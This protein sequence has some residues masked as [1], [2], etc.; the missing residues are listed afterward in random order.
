MTRAPLLRLRWSWRDLRARWLQ[1][2]AI[3]LVIGIGSGLYSGLSSVSEWRR[4][5]YPASYD[6]L[7]MFDVRVDFADGVRLDADRLEAAA[8]AGELER[9]VAAAEARLLVDVQVDASTSTE[10][11]L[12]PGRI[13]GVDTRDG[14]PSVNQVAAYEGR[15]LAGRDMRRPTAVIEATF[16]DE[17]GIT[18]GDTVTVSGDRE[19]EIVGTGSSPEQFFV[20]SDRGGFFAEFAYLYTSLGTAQRI[21]GEPGAADDLV[22]R[23]ADGVDVD[24]A[25]ALLADALQHAFPEAGFDLIPREEDPVLRILFDDIEGDQRL[26]DVFAVVILAGAAFAAF[27][28]V[29]RVVESQRREIG[30]AMALGVEPLHIS[31][32][33]LLFGAQVALLG[34]LFGVGVGALVGAGMS[35]V[36]ES[37][38][39]LPV[40]RTGFQPEVF[41]R[42]AVIGLLLPFAAAVLPV[43]R[44]VRVDPVDALRTN[45]TAGSGMV[46]LLR[47]V[48]LPGRSVS[49]MPI[50]NVLRTPRRTLLTALGIAAAIGTLVGVLGMIDSMLATVDASDEAIVATAPDRVLVDLDFFYPA[51]GPE[52]T[53]VMDAPTV[54]RAEP[55]LTVGATLDP[56]GEDIDVLLSAVQFDSEIWR[57]ATAAGELRDDVAGLVLTEKAADDIGVD[58]GDVVALRHPRREGLGATL[59]TS[60]LPVLAL[61]P[62]PFRAVVYVD[63]DQTAFMNLAGI[64]NSLQVLPKPGATVED[65]QRDLFGRPAVASVE[66]VEAAAEAVREQIDEFVSFFAILEGGVLVL[67]LLIAFNSTAINMDERAREHATMFAFGLP[68]R[69]VLRMAVTE[70]LLTGVLGTLIGFVLG[71]LLLA[72]LVNVLFPETLPDLGIIA[73]LSVETVVTTLLLGVVAVAVA[74]LF[75]VRRLRRMDIPSTL[76]VVE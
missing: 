44:A 14:G 54:G 51:D 69:S 53:A 40:W 30:I 18:A 16:A 68:V 46:G 9:V 22:V 38:F 7:A 67:A 70:S 43:V 1:V 32:R 74:P 25:S 71:R 20:M 10:T 37:F 56:G 61:H 29:G 55:V 63:S 24:E 17:H 13:V 57:P 2:A 59:V 76:R 12:V 58:V 50:R 48:P 21:A 72:W 49:E 36:L 73:S 62:N 75:T 26:Y 45:R 19:L 47:R 60:E 52:V 31:V 28:L 11:V 64:V 42:G 39:P 41:A 15:T 5:S 65:V 34:A 33:P 66:P 8:T 23:F 35:S 4:E 3:A 27:N 6:A